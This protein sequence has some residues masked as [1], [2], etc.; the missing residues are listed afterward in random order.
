MSQ[1]IWKILQVLVHYDG[2]TWFTKTLGCMNTSIIPDPVNLQSCSLLSFQITSRGQDQCCE[3]LDDYIDQLESIHRGQVGPW[4][5]QIPFKQ[6]CLKEVR[7]FSRVRQNALTLCVIRRGER[8]SKLHQCDQQPFD[9]AIMLKREQ[10]DLYIWQSGARINAWT[11][12][13]R[14][15]GL[16][17]WA[18]Y[19]GLNNLGSIRRTFPI[20]T[21]FQTWNGVSQKEVSALL[22]KT[23]RLGLDN[24]QLGWYNE[25]PVT[26]PTSIWCAPVLYFKRHWEQRA[27]LPPS[28][29]SGF[30]ETD[31]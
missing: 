18:Q 24:H 29:S 19:F 28:K 1:V 26:V 22:L 20:I 16:N 8:R 7:I 12:K 25:I 5:I 23:F 14:I 31:M 21:M 13:E 9:R 3:P 2:V 10:F 4:E 11:L 27:T 17:I 30:Q 6:E 15:F